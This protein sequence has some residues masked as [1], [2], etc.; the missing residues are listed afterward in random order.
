L[1]QSA[2]VARMPAIAKPSR[3]LRFV[4]DIPDFVIKVSWL[5]KEKIPT[6][7]INF[8]EFFSISAD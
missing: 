2:P 4:M 7:G 8:L 3:W 1:A 5:Q 6:N